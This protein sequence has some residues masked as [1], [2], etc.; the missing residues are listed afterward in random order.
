MDKE[1]TYQE[2]IKEAYEIAQGQYI[3]DILKDSQFLEDNKERYNNYTAS[4]IVQDIMEIDQERIE[5][6]AEAEL[7]KRFNFDD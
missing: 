3:K 7:Q 4:E 2:K 5:N 6:E 1:M